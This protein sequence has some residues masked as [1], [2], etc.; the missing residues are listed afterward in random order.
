M[1]QIG[2]FEC[3]KKENIIYETDNGYE[4]M[5]EG[6]K[7]Q[8]KLT[9]VELLNYMSNIIVNQSYMREKAENKVSELEKQLVEKS[10]D[11]QP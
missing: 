8:D 10:K 1:K 2:Y 5:C 6:K 3:N 9:Y 4:V 7:V 11:K